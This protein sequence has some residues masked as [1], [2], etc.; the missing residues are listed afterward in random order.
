MFSNSTREMAAIVAGLGTAVIFFVLDKWITTIPL[1]GAVAGY[2]VGGV[3]FLIGVWWMISS[4]GS[5]DESGGINQSQSNNPGGQQAA[6]AGRD[7]IQAG[8]DVHIGAPP[9][10]DR[11]KATLRA[12]ILQQIPVGQKLMDSCARSKPE[13][14]EQEY[15]TWVNNVVTLLN[16][17][18]PDLAVRFQLAPIPEPST[19]DYNAE[20]VTFGKHE[21][22]PEIWKRI[23]ILREIDLELS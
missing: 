14:L 22:W 2:S 8:R 3:L 4:G 16:P 21:L 23:Q 15:D 12:A 18:Y 7:I 17:D 1:W 10:R 9:G 20:G 19:Y 6:G 11:G 5:G 13:G